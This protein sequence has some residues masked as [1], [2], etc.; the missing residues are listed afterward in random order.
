MGFKVAKPSNMYVNNESVILNSTVPGSQ[1]NKK[2]VALSYH[3][4][5]EYVANKMVLIHKIKSTDNYA[6]P[7]TKGINSTDNGGF[8]HNILH[9]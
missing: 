6:D 3:F 2:H 4:V 9:N 1:L 5:R 8:F 7:F